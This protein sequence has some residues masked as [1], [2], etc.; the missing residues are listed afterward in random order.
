MNR[1]NSNSPDLNR[2]DL[3][4]QDII[5]AMAKE[6]DGLTLAMA[7]ASL[8][9]FITCINQ[10]L[11]KHQTVT[12]NNFGKFGVRYRQSRLGIHPQTQTEIQIPAT[13]VPF[14]SPSAGLKHLVNRTFVKN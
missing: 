11:A 3:T 1:Q 2:P 5:K 12:I 10:A 9:A 6:V 13:V 8:E 7:G 14:F 4:R